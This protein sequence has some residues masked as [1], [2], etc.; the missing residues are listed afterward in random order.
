MDAL[1]EDEVIGI[2]GFIKDIESNVFISDRQR[3]RLLKL[4]AAKATIAAEEVEMQLLENR[5]PD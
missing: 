5:T 1:L 4:L 3:V 2:C